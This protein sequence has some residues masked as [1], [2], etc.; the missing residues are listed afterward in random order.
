MIAINLLLRLVYKLNFF[1]DMYIQEQQSIHRVLYYLRFQSFTG[2]LEMYPL[3]IGR[4]YRN[5]PP[6]LKKSFPQY[7]FKKHLLT[8]KP[9]IPK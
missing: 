2:N 5:H 4:D 9:V 6:T 1:I 7:H 3:Q 8:P